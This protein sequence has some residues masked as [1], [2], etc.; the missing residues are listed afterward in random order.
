MNNTWAQNKN[1]SKIIKQLNLRR[2]DPDDNVHERTK[3]HASEQSE[4][5][6][7]SEA[8]ISVGRCVWGHAC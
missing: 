5:A 3:A 8:F 6:H 1:S 7:E 2:V 4:S